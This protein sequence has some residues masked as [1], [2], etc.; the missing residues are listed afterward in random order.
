MVSI[1]GYQ[2]MRDLITHLVDVHH[3]RKIAL[4]GGPE[5]HPYA[6]ERYHAFLDA[7]QEKGLTPD[8]NLVTPPGSWEKGAE[9]MRVLL[10]ERKCLPQKDFQAVVAASDLL[11]IGALSVL[12]E[13]GI[14]V[15]GDLAVVG[16]KD[17]EEG[18]LIRP[19]LTS[20][21]LPFYEQGRQSVEALL[22][23]L[24][25]KNV[26]QQMTLDSALL[27]R[28]SCGCPSQSVGLAAAELVAG[29]VSDPRLD[30]R[31][32]GIGCTNRPGDSQPGHRGDLGQTTDGRVSPGSGWDEPRTISRHAG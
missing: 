32:R 28:Q 6:Q 21:S 15:P 10:D 30:P 18:R 31:P 4:I 2:G 29:D 13:R 25:G 9:G 7:L 26:P 20:V 22:A 14:R 11:A 5:S 19:P 12:A 1:N 27:V 8:L 17:I 3:Y 16:F 24:S 23:K